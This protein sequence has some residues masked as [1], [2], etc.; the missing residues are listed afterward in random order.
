MDFQ[1]FINTYYN[2]F[3]K[4]YIENLHINMNSIIL[5]IFKEIL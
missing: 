5:I 1:K 3:I 4:L 2:Y